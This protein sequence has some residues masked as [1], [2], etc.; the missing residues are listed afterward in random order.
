MTGLGM[1]T[2]T[3]LSRERRAVSDSIAG[4]V[5]DCLEFARIGAVLERRVELGEMPRLADV[6]AK[7]SGSLAVRLEGWRDAEGKSW[8]QLAVS[9]KPVLCCQ[10]CL[11]GV[12]FSLDIHSRLRLIARG[13]PWPEDDLEDDSADAMDAAEELAVLSV[14]EDEVLLALPIAPRHEQCN[15]PSGDATEQG[16]SPFAALAALKMK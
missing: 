9:G 4:T 1:I 13:E 12:E 6:L 2:S 11:G 5:L 8:L 10:R 15:S 16:P 7:S 14:I 3:V